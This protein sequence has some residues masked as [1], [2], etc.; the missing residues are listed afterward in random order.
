MPPHE[1]QSIV[2]ETVADVFGPLRELQ[3]V[4]SFCAVSEKG[5]WSRLMVYGVHVSVIM[6]LA[7][8]LAG[9]ILGFKGFM[10]LPE[11]AATTR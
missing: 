3:C 4:D 2:K 9:S 5:R 10:D 7:G 1:A 6:V 8:A 11:G